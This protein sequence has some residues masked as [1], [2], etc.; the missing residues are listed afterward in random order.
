MWDFWGTLKNKIDF[1][2]DE[3]REGEAWF[4]SVE[5]N[6]RFVNEVT[7]SGG[8]G[9]VQAIS[10]GNAQIDWGEGFTLFNPITGARTVHLDS[11]GD[12]YFGSDVD[13]PAST[14]FVI[15]SNDAEYNSEDLG[16]GDILFG[17]NTSGMANLLWDRSTGDMYFRGGTTSQVSINTSGQMVAGGGT[18]TLDQHGLWIKAGITESYF[19]SINFWLDEYPTQIGRLVVYDQSDGDRVGEF[20]IVPGS[21]DS[22]MWINS[23]AGNNYAEI[24][25]EALTSGQSTYIRLK[26]DYD[27]AA[28]EKKQIDFVA[29]FVTFSSD[30]RVEGDTIIGYGNSS[31]IDFTLRGG[32]ATN[33]QLWFDTGTS[34]R[35]K[36]QTDN[37]AESGSDAGSD[38]EILAYDDSGS[39][40]FTPFRI[41]RSNGRVQVCA[42]GGDLNTTALTDY[43]GTSTITGW[44]SFTNK[45]LVYKR[46][47]HTV[48]VWFRLGGTSDSATTSFTLPRTNELG[49]AVRFMIRCNDNG[50]SFVIGNCQMTDGSATVTCYSDAGSTGWT[51]S[52]SKNVF[53]Y[54]CYETE[55][56]V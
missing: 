44:S 16:A 37:G 17:D 41:V 26:S 23:Y 18:V 15:L 6:A 39:W 21:A 19:N 5:R 38:F 56:T 11:D 33:R 9:F 14:S 22:Y 24:K 34:H 46:V 43:S 27:G 13:D 52:G 35:W 3:Q 12:A 45:D 29:D 25:L 48:H 42:G 36:I 7:S 40:N 49:F 55:V 32:A 2:P 4:A 47:G 30:M 51:A 54:I 31:N 1:T 50:G 20:M 28:G 10:A 8:G 53:G